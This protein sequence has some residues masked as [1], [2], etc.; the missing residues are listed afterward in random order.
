MRNFFSQFFQGRYGSYGMD[1]LTKFLLI[2]SVIAL[3]VSLCSPLGFLYYVAFA[4]LIYSY[5]RL[6]SKNIT[7]RYKENESFIRINQK[8]RLFFGRTKHKI[9]Q[10]K[11]Y[12]IYVC[13]KCKQKIRIP[14][15]AGKIMVRCPR[16]MTEFKKKA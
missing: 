4:L 2:L 8:I 7:K 15:G 1:K 11:N 10:S 12:H 6:L 9:N 16:C 3:I 14:R 13:P 5:Y